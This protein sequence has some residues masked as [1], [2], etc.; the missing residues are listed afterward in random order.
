MRILAVVLAAVLLIGVRTAG[1]CTCTVSE[2]T[3]CAAAL[4]ADAVLLGTVVRIDREAPPSDPDLP[5][6]LQRRTRNRVHFAS[7][8]MLKGRAVASVVTDVSGDSCGYTFTVGERYLVRGHA[9]RDGSV[10]TS[11]CSM[12]RRLSDA[13]A[14][15]RAMRLMLKEPDR[16]GRLVGRVY[17]ETQWAGAAPDYA[18]LAGVTVHV[19]GPV[20]RQVTT[21]RA[22]AF[23]IAGLPAGS[24]TAE[25]RRPPSASSI[26]NPESQ[27]FALT[28][29]DGCIEL[30]ALADA[31][32]RIRGSIVDEKG[33]PIPGAF[34]ELGVA[35]P[36]GSIVRGGGV[37]L[38]TNAL[39]R[40]E[41]DELP[42][43]LYAVGANVWGSAPSRISPFLRTFATTA[44]GDKTIRL[45]PGALVHLPPLRLVRLTE[46]PVAGVV[47]APNGASVKGLEV[48][49]NIIEPGGQQFTDAI[50]FADAEGRYQVRVW[51]GQRYR[52][53]VGP[54]SAPLI[55]KEFTAV[56]QTLNLALDRVPQQ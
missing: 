31:R 11:L 33:A 29:E 21:D 17:F 15:V 42:P 28:P 45:E 3:T 13:T 2:Y 24:F 20:A 7:V 14:L 46:M 32:G 56:E 43:G 39:G 30:L 48:R 25:F 19:R 16:G 41:F 9:G 26:E 37:G 35:R 44:A 4:E 51:R 34:L 10:G 54:A 27:E 55:D 1:A 52:V 36:D 12:N 49:F 5:P 40:F 6:E 47:S 38:S 18:G 22:G 50:G 53:I 8:E 23:E